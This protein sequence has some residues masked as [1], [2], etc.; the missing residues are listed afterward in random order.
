ML[1][2]PL[3]NSQQGEA[4]SLISPVPSLISDS[5]AGLTLP[6]SFVSARVRFQEEAGLSV[7][8][9]E[10]MGSMSSFFSR[11]ERETG[12]NEDLSEASEGSGYGSGSGVIPEG[13]GGH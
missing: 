13:S 1:P 5:F 3:P 10:A 8:I 2:V 7:Y 9:D 6:F 4:P 12:S 11:D